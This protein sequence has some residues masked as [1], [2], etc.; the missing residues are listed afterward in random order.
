MTQVNHVGVFGGLGNQL[1]QLAFSDYIEQKFSTKVS[2][3]DLSHEH[4][5]NRGWR[6]G[7]LGVQSSELSKADSL[8]IRRFRYINRLQR[9]LKK[10]GLEIPAYTSSV[11]HDGSIDHAASFPNAD[12]IF[13]GYWQK[14][15]FAETSRTKMLERFARSSGCFLGCDQVSRE[16]CDTYDPLIMHIRLGDYVSDPKTKQKHFVCGEDFY[17]KVL[18]TFFPGID[19][20][21]VWVFS[22]D[23]A[24]VQENFAFLRGANFV[25]DVRASPD[26]DLRRMML[27][28][29]FIISNSTFSWWAAFLSERNG[30]V[31][32]PQYWFRGVK[33]SD[34]EILPKSWTCLE[35][36]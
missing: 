13:V 17:Q 3:F 7:F 23:I 35:N 34:I 26:V 32:A 25:T 24:H 11:F 6:L 9:G 5:V 30:T 16:I 18:T 12:K 10:F 36:S 14:S 20:R 33:S 2:L 22:D 21:R 29:H 19:L 1:F 28:K 27:G 4:Q 15:S 31:I 8:T